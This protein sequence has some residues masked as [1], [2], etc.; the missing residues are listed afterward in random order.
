MKKIIIIGVLLLLSS[1]NLHSK[2]GTFYVPADTKPITF[3]IKNPEK[4]IWEQP[5]L[6]GLV[7]A[8]IGFFSSLGITIYNNKVTDRRKKEDEKKAIIK[9][10]RDARSE[11]ATLFLKIRKTA[12]EIYHHNFDYHYNN[13]KQSQIDNKYFGSIKKLTEDALIEQRSKKNIYDYIVADSIKYLQKFS[14]FLDENQKNDFRDLLVKL[15]Q[16]DFNHFKYINPIVEED[17]PMPY[18][19]YEK[20]RN[21]IDETIVH[22]KIINEITNPLQDILIAVLRKIKNER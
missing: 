13:L 4:K 16:V 10:L 6:I 15:I 19:N 14:Y 8:L 17:I 20:D 9:N 5:L 22:N 2:T 1:V 7:G 12:N 3:E 21:D 11:L 18:K